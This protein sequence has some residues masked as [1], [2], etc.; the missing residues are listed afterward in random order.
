MSCLTEP[1]DR[2]GKRSLDPDVTMASRTERWSDGRS[3]L[4]LL[5]ARRQDSMTGGGQK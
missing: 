5:Q 3:P 1:V 4:R 2:I